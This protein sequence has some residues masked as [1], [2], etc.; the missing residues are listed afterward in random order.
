MAADIGSILNEMRKHG[1]KTPQIIPS[2]KIN[3]AKAA[4]EQ[5]AGYILE[6]R[7]EEFVWMPEYDEIVDWL[8][9]NK[10]K[11]LFL[12]GKCGLGKTLISRYV[13]PAIILY[14]MRHTVYCYDMRE[15]NDNLDTA[16]SKKMLCID[17]I[18][19]EEQIVKFGDRRC[20]V[21]ELLDAT[22]KYGKL[23]I[24]TTNLT[25]EELRARYGDRVYDR[26]LANTKR[27]AF[28]G[29]SFRAK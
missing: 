20:A 28:N 9:D 8:T 18:G 15:L 26:I 1:M 14:I 27:I 23:I 3:N 22:E 16:L 4:I 29:K 25:G 13:I 21:T 2:V 7:G 12:Y 5:T 6:Q 11:G 17:D 19:T 10:N 24:I